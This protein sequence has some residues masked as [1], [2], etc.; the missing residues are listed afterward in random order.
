MTTYSTLLASSATSP[1]ANTV[2]FT[3][4]STDTCVVRDVEIYN[5][6]S[7]AVSFNLSFAASGVPGQVLVKHAIP[8]ADDSVQWSGRVVIPAGGTLSLFASAGQ[9]SYSIS[10]YLLGN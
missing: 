6:S 3:V 2:I 10:G 5:Y 1:T 9:V 4:P 8:P 7:S